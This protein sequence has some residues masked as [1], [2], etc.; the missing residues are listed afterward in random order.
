M[1]KKRF[2]VSAITGFAHPACMIVSDASKF[3]CTLFLEY[4]GDSINLKNSV[5]SIMDLLALGIMP[6]DFVEIGAN[7]CDEEKALQTLEHSLRQKLY[8]EPSSQ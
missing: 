8:M 5:K 6:G 1:I 2:K 3:K 4:K 7:G